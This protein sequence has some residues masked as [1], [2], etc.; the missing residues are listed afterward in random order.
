MAVVESVTTTCVLLLL[1]VFLCIKVYYRSRY[2][3]LHFQS[4]STQDCKGREM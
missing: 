3:D 4:C 1:E 2:N